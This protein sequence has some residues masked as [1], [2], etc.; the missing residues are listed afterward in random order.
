MAS[1]LK[2]RPCCKS[3]DATWPHLTAFAPVFKKKIFRRKI[4]FLTE[5]NLARLLLGKPGSAANWHF[6]C[7]RGKEERRSEDGKREHDGML[8]GKASEKPVSQ[9]YP[10]VSA[11]PEAGVLEKTPGR[12]PYPIETKHVRSLVVVFGTAK[13]RLGCLPRR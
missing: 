4:F 5:P 2:M 8:A 9:L 11:S 10:R 1:F 3:E 6:A 12:G 7:P 13:N